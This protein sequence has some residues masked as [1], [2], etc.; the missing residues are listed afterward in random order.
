MR[1]LWGQLSA[2]IAATA[3]GVVLAA[4]RSTSLPACQDRRRSTAA[5]A[6]MWAQEAVVRDVFSS[7]FTSGVAL[8]LLRFWEELAKRGVFEQTLSR[9][10]VHIS[11]GLTFMLFWPMFS[12]GELAP[13]LAAIAPV[14]NIIRM[15]FLGLGI[16]RNDAIVK[17]MSRY[18]D[19]R[20]LLKGPLFYACTITLATT[21][22]WR[23]SPVAIAAVCN[24]CAGDGMA[25]PLRGRCHRKA[26]R[27]G[28]TPYNSSKS[29]AGSV[30]MAAAGF[31]ASVG[32]MYY[33]SL[34]GF[35]E[36]SWGKTLGFLLVSLAATAVESLPI[37]SKF[38]DNLTVPLTSFL[39]GSL[40]F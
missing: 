40:V 33:Y 14:F 17:S 11:V 36:V 7:A 9:K 18:G 5:R 37:S 26:I 12:S 10:L 1:I 25:L 4:R 19:Y 35:V 30:A 24:L 32:Y 15:I 28:Q 3:G 13:F 22:F 38:D 16:W 6:S 8:S 20:E 27:K 29:Y 2:P 31:L 23:T 39:V 21:V 34:F